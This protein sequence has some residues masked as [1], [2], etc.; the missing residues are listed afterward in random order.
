MNKYAIFRFLARAQTT[1]LHW[2]YSCRMT[3]MAVHIG[4]PLGFTFSSSSPI[5]YIG[6]AINS[7]FH[8]INSLF[9]SIFFFI[10][11]GIR[12]SF[13]HFGHFLAVLD[14]KILHLLQLNAICSNL[15][16]KFIY[17]YFREPFAAKIYQI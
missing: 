1:A 12:L 15:I 6:F 9:G 5:E 7:S 17:F 16:S 8:S 2:Q 13:P 4:L 14:T 11:T 10:L 3:S